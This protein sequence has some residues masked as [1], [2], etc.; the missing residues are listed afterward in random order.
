[1]QKIL[2]AEDSYALANLL[3]FVLQSAGFE[4]HV[5]PTGRT[6]YEAA[7]GQKFD[8]ILLDQQM[9]EMTGVEVAEALREGDSDNKETPIFLCTA[10]T[11]ELDLESIKDQL[12]LTGVFHKPFSPKDLVDK[13]VKETSEISSY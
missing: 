1:M 6:A 11:H 10:K 8:M 9:P 2:V 4:V 7:L 12:Q 13:L 5:F 3:E